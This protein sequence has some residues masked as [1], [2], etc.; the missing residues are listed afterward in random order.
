MDYKRGY[1]EILA[2][3]LN[4]PAAAAAFVENYVLATFKEIMI[5]LDF[6]GMIIFIQIL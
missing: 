4:G 5:S 3:I 2:H 1:R 6:Y